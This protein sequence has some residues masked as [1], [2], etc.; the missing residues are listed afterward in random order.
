MERGRILLY[1][2]DQIKQ[3]I[4]G[5]GTAFLETGPYKECS[6]DDIRALVG[7]NKIKITRRYNSLINGGYRVKLP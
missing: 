5:D 6:E 4:F 3:N 2:Q 7:E 1:V